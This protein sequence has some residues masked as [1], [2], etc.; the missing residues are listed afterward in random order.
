MSIDKLFLSYEI[1]SYD[2]FLHLACAF[3]YLGDFSIAKISFDWKILY[4]ADASVN[5]N[6]LGGVAICHS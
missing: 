5:L 1:A 4:V 3:V 6:R 2:E